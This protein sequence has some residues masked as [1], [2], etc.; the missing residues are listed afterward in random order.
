[1]I[2]SA[3]SLGRAGSWSHLGEAS[4]LSLATVPSCTSLRHRRKAFVTLRSGQIQDS[5]RPKMEVGVGAAYK[6]RLR[7]RYTV[8][9]QGLIGVN[10]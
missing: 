9:S 1:M 2:R 6:R 4:P 10:K 7:A 3:L 8:G 5:S